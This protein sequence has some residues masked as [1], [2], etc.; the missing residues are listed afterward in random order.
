MPQVKPQW[1]VIDEYS[2]MVKKLVTKY[3]EKFSHIDPSWIVAYESNK[4]KP[5]KK[6]KPYDMNGEPEPMNFTNSKRYFIMFHQGEWDSR[7]DEAK[8]ALIFSALLR[9][10]EDEASSGKV[11]PLDYRD[12]NL[13]VR[14]F[15]PDWQMRGVLP[16]LLN[17]NVDFVENPRVE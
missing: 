12:Q 8:L 1:T 16:H 7:S 10:P 14:T 6:S 3:P 17:D 5:E 9:I 4:D 15:G 13:M 2:E 11:G